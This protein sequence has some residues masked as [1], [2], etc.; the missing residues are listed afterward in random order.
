MPERRQVL[1]RED[2]HLEEGVKEGKRLPDG[3]S[4]LLAADL[5]GDGTDDLV[6]AGSSN[7]V[8]FSDLPEVSTP[9]TRS[10]SRQ[11][12]PGAGRRGPQ[13]RRAGS[14]WFSPTRETPGIAAGVGDFLGYGKGIQPRETNAPPHFVRDYGSSGR[15]E[16]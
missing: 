12:L 10:S 2:L 1:E 4:T 3:M 11:I 15:S 7:G 5:N 13:P 6:A 14:I 16:P 9:G 8:C